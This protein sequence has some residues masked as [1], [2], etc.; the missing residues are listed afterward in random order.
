MKTR[1][2][3]MMERITWPLVVV[4]VTVGALFAPASAV[5]SSGWSSPAQIDSV[6]SLSSVSCP[7]ASFCVAVGGE[8]GS[9]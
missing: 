8:F 6:G 9:G 1:R 7:S 5:A 2:K 4:C 3:L